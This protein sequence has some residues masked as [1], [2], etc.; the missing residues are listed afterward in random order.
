[1][2]GV[3]ASTAALCVGALGADLEVEHGGYPAFAEPKVQPIQACRWRHGRTTDLSHEGW[4]RQDCF[5][6]V[7]GFGGGLDFLFGVAGLALAKAPL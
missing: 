6:L 1:M 3:K 7:V 5:P 2:R 4:A